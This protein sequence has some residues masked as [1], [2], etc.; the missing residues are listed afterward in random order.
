MDTDE[1]QI[2]ADN[3]DQEKSQQKEAEEKN[4]TTEKFRE[5][6]TEQPPFIKD[7]ELLPYQIKGLNFLHSGWESRSNVVLA[8]DEELR[9]I[10]QV[11]AF[12]KSIRQEKSDYLPFLVVIPFSYLEIWVSELKRWAPEFNVLSY[13]GSKEGRE[14]IRKK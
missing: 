14:V 10:V 11:I 6:Y 7:N 13:F 5:V 4:N 12:M 9:T 8:D 1:I 3:D 2:F